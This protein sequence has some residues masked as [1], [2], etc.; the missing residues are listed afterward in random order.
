MSK[1][2]SLEGP[3]LGPFAKM[4]AGVQGIVNY[5]KFATATTATFNTSAKTSS[6]SARF[7]VGIIGIIAGGWLAGTPSG[8]SI[9]RRVRGK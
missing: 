7:I 9:V 4:R 1:I 5:D 3:R 6:S 8:Q 2:M